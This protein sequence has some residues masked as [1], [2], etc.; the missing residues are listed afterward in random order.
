MEA[1]RDANRIPVTL[2]TSNADGITPLMLTVNPVTH[3]IFIDDNTTGSDLSSDIA[4]RDANRV[5]VL[6]GVSS[7]DGITPVPIY[8]DPVTGALLTDSN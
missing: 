8:Q 3:A 5:P 4:S 2:V 6:M 1:G 7:V